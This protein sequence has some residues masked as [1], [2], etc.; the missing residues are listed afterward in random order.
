VRGLIEKVSTLKMV[1][2]ERAKRAKEVAKQKQ[3]LKEAKEL[4]GEKE[5]PVPVVAEKAPPLNRGRFWNRRP[6]NS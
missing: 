5:S 4:K 6:S 1:R 3:E 2:K